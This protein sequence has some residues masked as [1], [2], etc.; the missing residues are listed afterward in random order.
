M[1]A[2]YHD[3]PCPCGFGWIRRSDAHRASR[4]EVNLP[5]FR[6]SG[7]PRPPDCGL[8]ACVFN[9]GRSKSCQG[10]WAGRLGASCDAEYL[11]KVKSASAAVTF[12]STTHALAMIQMPNDGTGRKPNGAFLRIG[13]DR[14]D[15]HVSLSPGFA[16]DTS[17][18]G[19]GQSARSSHGNQ[20]PSGHLERRS[21]A[22]KVSAP[23][24]PMANVLDDSART[25]SQA[26]T[27]KRLKFAHT[28]PCC[29]ARFD[30]P[31][32]VKRL[33]APETKPRRSVTMNCPPSNQRRMPACSSNPKRCSKSS[34]VTS[35]SHL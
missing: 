15:I 29:L 4:H 24:E 30:A 16:G 21:V 34:I 9:C 26:A 8:L 11:V 32:P 3:F 12:A 35:A 20:C 17:G 27:R 13:A 18:A 19:R 7:D 10:L 31:G 28:S 14:H 25:S 22:L 2:L 6:R 23:I 5:N 1:K 33:R